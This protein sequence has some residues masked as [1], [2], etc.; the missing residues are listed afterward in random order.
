MLNVLELSRRLLVWSAVLLLSGCASVDFDYPKS[1]STA[2]RGTDDTYLGRQLSELDDTHPGESGFHLLTDGIDALASRILI[3]ERAERTLDAQYY[4]ITND[5]IGFAF[6]GALLRAADRGVRVRL[7][8]DD[9]Q[10]KGYDTG[11]AALDSHPNFEVR[12]FNPF[13]VRGAR[14]LNFTDLG[15]V[16]RR[17]HNKSMTADN[18]ITIIG[19]R[20]IAAEYFAARDDVNFGDVDVV[21][22]GP[23]VHDV[24]NMFDTYWNH[25]QAAPVP[26][27]AKMPDD[28][29][30]ELESL[31]GR[32][33]AAKQRLRETTYVDAFRESYSDAIEQDLATFTWSTY[34]LVY[35]SPDKA[36][37]KKAKTA[38]SIVTSLDKAVQGAKRELIVVSPYFVP[39]K[40]GVKYLAD[41]E[42]RGVDVIIFTN[43]LAATNHSV[44]HSG[45]APY[46]K[47]L[48]ESGI[49][50]REVRPD[51]FVA[52]VDRVAQTDRGGAGA[53]LAT[54]HTKA[55]IVDR[56][57]FFLGSFNWDPRSID[58]NTELGVIMDSP[59]LARFAVGKIIET[60]D[61]MT[62]E[63]VLNDKGK[64]RWV[65]RSGDEEVILDKEPQTGFWRR[66]SV[67]FYRILPIKGQL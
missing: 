4:L 64:V 36:D 17:M 62:Y 22:I 51:A 28:P 63:V 57:R 25:R 6:V 41:L 16:N 9:I 29:A 13:G 37:K 67:G 15:R 12:I 49:E 5:D 10:T 30:V 53:S 66:F 18:Q 38:E 1:E 45:Y 54:L 47:A 52:G 32:V 44:V 61:E 20:N 55:F 8:L 23:V 14:G 39:L 40:S 24:S 2:L 19:G 21:G 58:I 31:R 26:A 27:F 42:A 60:Q 35:D 48:L 65:D 34:E 3:A 59:E 56:E 46:R 7:L 43:S 50:L 33:E 11:M